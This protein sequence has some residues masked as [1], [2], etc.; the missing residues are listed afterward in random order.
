MAIK[1]LFWFYVGFV[2]VSF[3]SSLWLFLSSVLTV[4]PIPLP[5][6]LLYTLSN[7]VAAG[8][9]VAALMLVLYTYLGVSLVING[10]RR[11]FIPMVMVFAFVIGF[12]LLLVRQAIPAL[13]MIIIAYVMLIGTYIVIISVAT[14]RASKALWEAAAM[15]LALIPPMLMIGGLIVIDYVRYMAITEQA[16]TITASAVEAWRL[17]THNP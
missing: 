14:S 2:L 4:M 1:S 3:A 6:W 16:T 17:G 11:G 8:V 12:A 9:V 15:V 10:L 5:Y 7:I 13:I